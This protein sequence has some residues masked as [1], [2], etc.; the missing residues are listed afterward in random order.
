MNDNSEGS[1]EEARQHLTQLVG[2]LAAKCPVGPKNPEMCP[3][4]PVRKRRPSARDRWIESLKPEDLE[5]V[6]TYHKVCSKWQ[7]AGR[8]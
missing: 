2:E 4:Y 8:P 5:F 3:L 1:A 6:V 7:Q